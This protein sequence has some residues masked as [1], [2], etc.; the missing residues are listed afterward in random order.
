[1]TSVCSK[2]TLGVN[3][4]I[5]ADL[6]TMRIFVTQDKTYALPAGLEDAKGVS[7]SSEFW[8]TSKSAAQSDRE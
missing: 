6:S 5:R 8:Q 4:Q 3:G 7:L 1:M 2:E